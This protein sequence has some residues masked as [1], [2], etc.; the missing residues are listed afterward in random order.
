MTGLKFVV[1]EKRSALVVSGS[2][3]EMFLQNLISNDVTKVNRQRAIY[4]TLLTPQGK[5]LHDFFISAHPEVTGTYVLETEADRIG[6]L[7]KRLTMYRLHADVTLEPTPSD[8]GTLAAFGDAAAKALKLELVEGTAVSRACG[9]VYVD[10]RL[11]RLGVRVFGL[12]EA[13]K[14]LMVEAGFSATDSQ[15]YEDMRLSLGIPDG[16]RDILIEKSFPLECN[17]D[18]LHAIDYEKGCY[19][20]QELTARTHHRAKIRK[21]LFPVRSEGPVP[22]AG[23]SVTFNGKEIGEM[24]SGTGQQGLALLRI[25][26]LRSAYNQGQPL[27]VEG[28]AIVPIIPPWLDIDDIKPN[29]GPD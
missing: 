16:S 6:D 22:E 23:V 28:T 17:L 5:F 18:D 25:E 2:D 21:R 10:P 19:V 1:L 7:E 29:V 14:D 3:A 20:G 26:S 4:A 11:A 13:V 8:W 24:R 15:E 9:V 27:M 12:L